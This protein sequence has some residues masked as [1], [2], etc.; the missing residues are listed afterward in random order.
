M[1]FKIDVDCGGIDTRVS[2]PGA[3]QICPTL[4]SIPRHSG[5]PQIVSYTFNP[6]QPLPSVSRRQYLWPV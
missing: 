1:D 5:P 2:S 4:W 6:A 3:F